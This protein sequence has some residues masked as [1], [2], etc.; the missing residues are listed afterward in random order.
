L[1]EDTKLTIAEVADLSGMP[2]AAIRDRLHER[3]ARTNGVALALARQDGTPPAPADGRRGQEG[4]PNRD[5]EAGVRLTL[6]LV[7]H[8]ERQA[9][10][11]AQ[12]RAAAGDKESLTEELVGLRIER[13][14]LQSQLETARA[15][16]ESLRSHMAS[17]RGRHERRLAIESEL[18]RTQADLEATR[19]QLAEAAT[20]WRD[21]LGKPSM[22][23]FLKDRRARAQETRQKAVETELA[24]A[25]GEVQKAH[26]RIAELEQR[27]TS[28]TKLE[29][30]LA[31]AQAEVEAARARIAELT[32]ERRGWRGLLRNGAGGRAIGERTNGSD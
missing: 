5:H 16:I 11:I 20:T 2:E 22:P 12:L 32:P 14:D 19:A 27:D 13:D 21:W 6:E 23:A 10:E 17:L 3:A 30:D 7:E 28:R 1:G 18:V 4:E 29:Q 9:A 8:V 26:R 31:V 25:R 15:E 24:E